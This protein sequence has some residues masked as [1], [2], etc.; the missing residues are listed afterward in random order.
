MIWLKRLLW[1]ILIRGV[2][3]DGESVLLLALARLIACPELS[4]GL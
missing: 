2:E 1:Q 3:K 4:L